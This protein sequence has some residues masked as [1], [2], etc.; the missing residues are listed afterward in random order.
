MIISLSGNLEA[1]IGY[2]AC[3]G[4]AGARASSTKILI[5]CL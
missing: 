3:V 5:A 1:M 4:R 2:R